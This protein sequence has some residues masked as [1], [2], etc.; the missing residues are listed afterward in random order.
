MTI[1]DVRREMRD[2][3]V[4]KYG[5]REAT[6]I[7]RAVIMQLKGWSMAEMLANEQREA[8]EFIIGRSR[9]IL[10]Q[11]IKDVPLQYA[12]GETVFYGLTLKVRSGV[13]IPRPETE[14]LVDL[15]VKQNRRDD[16]R[17]LDL[18]T[19][20]GAI[21]L[22]LARNLPFSQVEAIDISPEAIAV[23]TENNN[24]LKTKVSIRQADVFSLSLPEGGFD[25]IVSN[26]PYVCESEKADMEPNVLSY[27]P[28]EALFVPDSNPLLFYRRIAEL[29]TRA[30]AP[31]GRLY[32]E[33]NPR[34]ASELTR[35]LQSMGYSEV[36]TYRDVHGKERFISA[37][38]ATER[39]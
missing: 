34:F 10:S 2:A 20:S 39:K 19:G 16:L 33:I 24:S 25:I 29:G 14:E 31:D 37:I 21:A 13:L 17:V 18:C 4:A 5:E 27:E 15:I 8:S 12:L 11:L 3:L 9:E 7:A 23:A 22:A 32:F 26:P 35:L 30:L 28:P 6:A 36:E 1:A 38:T